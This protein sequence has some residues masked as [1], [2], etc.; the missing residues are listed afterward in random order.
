MWKGKEVGCRELLSCRIA[1]VHSCGRWTTAEGE[2]DGSRA[3]SWLQKVAAMVQPQGEEDVV[4]V[5]PLTG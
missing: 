2:H 3:G 4:I 1:A 5:L